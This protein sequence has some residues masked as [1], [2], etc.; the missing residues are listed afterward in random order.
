ML[1]CGLVFS[2]A[3]D[4]HQPQTQAAE[5]PYYNY[6][7]RISADSEFILDYKSVSKDDL[8]KVYGP[9]AV[10]HKPARNLYE[11]HYNGSLVQFY[12][13]DGF[14]SNVQIISYK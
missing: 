9:P 7:G 1:T 14:V 5:N 6:S 8:L 11:R 3:I 12:V 2:T 10:T 13:N 4:S